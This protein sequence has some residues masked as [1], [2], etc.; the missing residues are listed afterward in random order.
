MEVVSHVN[1]MAVYNYHSTWKHNTDE[2][3]FMVTTV[4]TSN[5]ISE[6]V[7]TKR[8]LGR[9]NDEITWQAKTRHNCH[10]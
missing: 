3:G 7:Y 4:R 10:H 5:F 9:R 6:F 8:E 2:V 1:P